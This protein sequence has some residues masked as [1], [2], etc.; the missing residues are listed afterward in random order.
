MSEERIGAVTV[1]G[2][3]LTLIGPEL[4]AGMPAPPFTLVANDLSP[5]TLAD[6]TGKVRIFSVV[7]SLDTP[8]CD[9]Q[10][11][12]F[13]DEAA[14]LDGV[15]IYTV[16]MDLPFSQSRWCAT[17]GVDRLVTLSD[18]REAQFGLNWGTL[19][20]ETRLECRAL[21]VVDAADFIRHAE[22]VGDIAE[23]P[24]YDAALSVVRGLA[25]GAA[26]H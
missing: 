24:D 3:P 2:N 5:V 18:H 19:V 7:P 26:A 11:R 22:Y 14:S 20:K 21:F 12:R 15:T 10:T 1:G 6:T 23:Q 25:A 17:A 8:V 4:T 16:S 13:N 9:T